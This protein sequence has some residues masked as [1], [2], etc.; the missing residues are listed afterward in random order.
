MTA[1]DEETPV[2]T[3]GIG[4]RARSAAGWGGWWFGLFATALMLFCA[5][6]A[7]L[8][9]QE[10]D[11][12][13]FVRALGDDVVA[14]LRDFSDLEHGG[15]YTVKIYTST[16][17]AVED[18]DWGH[19]QIVLRPANKMEFE[20]IELGPDDDVAVMAEFIEVWS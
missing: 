15:R 3:C 18:V 14:V 17:R 19:E 6:S 4:I 2:S 10:R 7:Q 5:V 8:C 20:P 9:A 13:A 12:S 11:A 16:K 1:D